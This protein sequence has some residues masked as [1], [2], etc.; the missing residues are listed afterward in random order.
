MAVTIL[1][2]I[3][4]PTKAVKI[5]VTSTGGTAVTIRRYGDAGGM[6]TVVLF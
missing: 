3:E 2:D 5:I 1:A 4:H 6:G